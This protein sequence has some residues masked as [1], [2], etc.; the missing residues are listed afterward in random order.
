MVAQQARLVAQT[1]SRRSVVLALNAAAI[2]IGAAAGSALGALVIEIDGEGA[3]GIGA[4]LFSVLALVHLV[5]SE[6][7]ARR[8]AAPAAA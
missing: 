2:Y 7:L 3:L 6:R 4:G 1:P 5:A 8:V